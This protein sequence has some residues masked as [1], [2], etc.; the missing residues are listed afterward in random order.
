MNIAVYTDV[1]FEDKEAFSQFVFIHMISHES[2]SNYITDQ[3]LAV[4]N[5]PM[6]NLD[7]KRDWMFTHNQAH[8]QIAQR[9]GLTSP[10]DLELYDLDESSE[11]YDWM[12]LHGNEHDRILLAMGF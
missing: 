2:I 10:Q 6:D 3:N 9:L 8:I 12:A 5:Y 1:K 4:T 11:F 7:D